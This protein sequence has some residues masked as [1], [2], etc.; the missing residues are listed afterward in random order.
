[1]KRFLKRTKHICIVISLSVTLIVLPDLVLPH[2]TN[3]PN[4]SCTIMVVQA[5]ECADGGC[6]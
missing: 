6:G 1:M 4:N 2:L 3:Q 5:E